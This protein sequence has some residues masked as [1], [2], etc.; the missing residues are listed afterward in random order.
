MEKSEIVVK[1]SI[2]NRFSTGGLETLK[3]PSIREDL[4]KFHADYYSAN[5][6]NLVMVGKQ[7]LEELESLAVENFKDVQDKGVKLADFTKDVVYDHTS[8]GHIFKVVPNKNL[9]NLRILWNLPPSSHL[10]KSKPMGYISYLIGHEG[11][12][13][14]LSQ[15]IKEGL[16]TALSS[17]ADNR[18]QQQLDQF[19]IQITL[20]DKGERHYERV[21]SLVYMYIN[22]LK[23]LGIL[24]FIHD[25]RKRMNTIGF[26]NIT[27][28]TALNYAKSIC[29]KLSYTHDEALIPDLLWI[30]YALEEFSPDEI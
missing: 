1:G 17:S 26:D 11:P 30:P 2:L 7:S 29:Y 18:L 6:M 25:E 21:L 4:L 14:L 12:N 15:L 5:I 23:S 27:K 9:K 8:M 20:T 24:D 10:W 22:N 19:R 3:I 28:T 13:S 16:A